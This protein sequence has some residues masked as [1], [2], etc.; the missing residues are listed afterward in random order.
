MTTASKMGFEEEKRV[1][2]GKGNKK[3]KL[4]ER[5]EKQAQGSYAA[6]KVSQGSFSP[7]TKT[8]T[9]GEIDVG[10]G[11]KSN[12]SESEGFSTF[13][14]PNGLTGQRNVAMWVMKPN[15]VEST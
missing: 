9:V 2:C 8:K 14:Y 15:R 6:T 12:G 3:A 1:E 13:S 4:K 5:Y 11:S 7:I 10:L